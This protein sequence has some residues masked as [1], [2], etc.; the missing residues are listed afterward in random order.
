MKREFVLTESFEA[1]WKE[2]RLSDESIRSLQDEL[3]RDP[4]VGD[5]MRGTGGFRKMRFAFPGRGKSGSLRVIYLDVPEFS[6]LYLM[7]AYPKNEKDNLSPAER[8]ELK[9][10]AGN[11]KQNL[12]EHKRKGNNHA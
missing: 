1:S 3:L 12:R 10:I 6:T 2:Q 11:I 4:A 5:V 8:N 7:L 9:Q